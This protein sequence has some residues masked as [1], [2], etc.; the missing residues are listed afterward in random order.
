MGEEDV[1]KERARRRTQGF[2]AGNKTQSHTNSSTDIIKYQAQLGRSAFSTPAATK[3]RVRISMPLS[4]EAGQSRKSAYTTRPIRH[5]GRAAREYVEPFLPFWELSVNLQLPSLGVPGPGQ[6]IFVLPH[7]IHSSP[8]H[9]RTR[10]TRYTW[11][12]EGVCGCVWQT[13]VHQKARVTARHKR[14]SSREGQRQTQPRGG[15]GWRRKA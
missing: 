8:M 11:I 4:S 2:Y 1:G 12:T 9:A 5:K 6:C 3:A 13:R 14:G 7:R 10:G 15:R